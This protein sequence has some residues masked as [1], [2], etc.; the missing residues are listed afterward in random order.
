MR[1]VQEERKGRS[2]GEDGGRVEMQKKRRQSLT[3]DVETVLVQGVGAQLSDTMCQ[4][5]QLPVQLLS[6]QPGAQRV[7]AVSADSIHSSGFPIL[8]WPG[9]GG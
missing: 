8:L 3:I 1:G 6:V 4:L 2:E 7:G 9:K 5:A